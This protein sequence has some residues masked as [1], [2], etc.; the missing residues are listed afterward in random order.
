MAF[1]FPARF[2]AS[3]TFPLGREELTAH[4]RSALANLEWGSK[5]LSDHELLVYPPANALSWGEEMTVEILDGG[6]VNAQSK[7]TG[8]GYKPQIFDFGKNK[9]N[10]ETFFAAIAHLIQT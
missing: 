5:T 7:C 8:V 2:K 6:I 1:G 4:V 10:V 3:R 9:Q